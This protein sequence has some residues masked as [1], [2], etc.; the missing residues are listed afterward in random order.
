MTSRETQ[1]RVPQMRNVPLRPRAWRAL[2]ETPGAAIAEEEGGQVALVPQDGELHLYWAFDSVEQM[3]R[4]FAPL[5]E[6]LKPSI[7]EDAA[8]Y[9][10]LNLV[11]VHGKEWLEPILRDADFE[12]FAE[13]LEMAHPA[14]DPNSVP[15]FPAGVTMR[16]AKKG[17]LA[18]V[19]EI[20]AQA[21]GD[22]ADGP[23]AI[24]EAVD[25]ASWIGVLEGPD[26]VIGFAANGAVEEAQ[27]RVLTAAV[28]PEAR[29]NGFGTLLLRAA[30]YQLSTKDARAATVIARPDVP[31]ALRTC[32]AAGFRP[33]RAG[34]E[35]RRTTDEDAIHEKREARRLA[36]VKARFG[37]W[38]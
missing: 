30:V 3:R 12:F 7:K 32:S 34:L 26:G 16:R 20:W 2:L 27:G 8:D 19:R 31:Q 9:V 11:E 22:V 37:D 28:A 24:A 6:M 23:R 5:F 25:S 18:W 4:S 33:G 10:V 21:Y 1:A 35:Y 14:L 38:R 15:E 29:G 13:W 36:G 17:D